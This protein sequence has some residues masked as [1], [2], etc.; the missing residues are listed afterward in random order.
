MNFV[1]SL[2]ALLV[3]NAI[4]QYF[5]P[6]YI[7][8]PV[9]VAI[10]YFGGLSRWGAFGAG[11]LSM[12]LLWVGYALYLDNANNHILSTKVA[13]ILAALTGGT[14]IGLL[15]LTGVVGGLVSGLATL[16]G[17]LLNVITAKK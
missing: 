5:L 6:W 14:G 16:S 11:F 15:L 17:K 2:L 12:F 9:G 1:K 13:Q 3:L 7:M 4:L 8:V 10:G